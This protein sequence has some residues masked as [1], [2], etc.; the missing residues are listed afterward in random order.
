MSEHGILHLDLI[1]TGF[2]PD[3]TVPPQKFL[4]PFRYDK[5]LGHRAKI[6]QAYCNSSKAGTGLIASLI[7]P[8]GSMR[9]KFSKMFFVNMRAVRFEFGGVMIWRRARHLPS[10]VC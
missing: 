2:C 1:H 3:L 5:L 10:D 9:S 8:I 4:R 7:L 6:K